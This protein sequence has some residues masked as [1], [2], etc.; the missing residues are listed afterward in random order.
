M[1]TKVTL[2]SAGRVRLPLALRNALRLVPGDTFALD[3][4]GEKLTLKP[5]RQKSAMRKEQGIW[6]F[7]SG[8]KIGTAKTD[9]AL[10]K[11]RLSRD[12]T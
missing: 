3:F 12:R 4:D 1:N 11:L 9:D 2:D 7:R 10:A 5:A 6:V 8:A